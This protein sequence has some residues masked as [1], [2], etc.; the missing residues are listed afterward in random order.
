MVEGSSLIVE[1]EETMSA[2]VQDFSEFGQRRAI[3]HA[4]R[5][6]EL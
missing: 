5:H 3:I 4:Q 2:T 1:D 6:F